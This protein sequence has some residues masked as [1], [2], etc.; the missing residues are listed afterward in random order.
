[1]D[2]L[3]PGFDSSISGSLH[4]E[5]FKR[6]ESRI[7]FFAVGKC[8]NIAKTINNQTWHVTWLQSFPFCSLTTACWDDLDSMMFFA[9]LCSLH[10]V[11]KT[12]N[13]TNWLDSRHSLCRSSSLV[14]R[15]ALTVAVPFKNRLAV[16]FPQSGAPTHFWDTPNTTHCCQRNQTFSQW[17]R[18]GFNCC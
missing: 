17:P 18:V 14:W 4:S 1:M 3:A 7:L 12:M 13:R 10:L 2:P 16:C 9:L 6:E 5:Y 11:L 8:V 15:S